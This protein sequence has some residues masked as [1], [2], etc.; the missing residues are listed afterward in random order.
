MTSVECTPVLYLALY[1]VVQKSV[2]Q[3]S[4][5]VF[6]FYAHHGRQLQTY[7]YLQTAHCATSYTFAY[8]ASW[9]LPKVLPN[10]AHPTPSV[11]SHQH[12]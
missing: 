4:P 7:L 1:Y 11:R 10:T 2:P 3:G 12:N 6:F 5:I 9:V 8:F